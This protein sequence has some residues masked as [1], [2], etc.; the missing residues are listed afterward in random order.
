MTE[1]KTVHDSG[2]YNKFIN[3]SNSRYHCEFPK[4]VGND[5]TLRQG[6]YST[7]RFLPT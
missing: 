4:F 3:V 6:G 7:N 2:I 5:T 1:Y